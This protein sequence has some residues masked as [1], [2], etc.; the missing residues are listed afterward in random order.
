MLLEWSPSLQLAFSSTAALTGPH[1]TPGSL[2][3]LPCVCVL[4]LSLQLFFHVPRMHVRVL[5]PAHQLSPHAVCH[6]SPEF[7]PCSSGLAQTLSHVQ[8]HPVSL[9]LSWLA[10]GR[11]SGNGFCLG[12]R[13]SDSSNR[14]QERM[15][16]LVA[17]AALIF[18]IPI[19]RSWMMC[20]VSV[21][22]CVLYGSVSYGLVNVGIKCKWVTPPASLHRHFSNWLLNDFI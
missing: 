19:V 12:R 14:C 1:P 4:A 9:R 10:P 8:V 3:P 20:H 6:Q 5:S 7:Q 11:S 18:N 15:N 22:I 17:F 13:E 16:Q 21:V 2:F